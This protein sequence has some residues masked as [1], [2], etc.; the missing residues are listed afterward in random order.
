MGK[1]RPKKIKEQNQTLL[2]GQG[3]ENQDNKANGDDKKIL[4]EIEESIELGRK[5]FISK[6]T[7][8][9][10]M[11]YQPG[12]DIRQKADIAYAIKYNELLKDD[13]P[14][15]KEMLETLKKRGLWTDKDDKKIENKIEEMRELLKKKASHAG[16][17]G[18]ED[19]INRLSD[20]IKK[21][22]T[23]L[24]IITMD[25]D[26]M[27][28]NTIE[29]LSLIENYKIK[30]LHCVKEIDKDQ[31]EL[32]VWESIKELNIEKNNQFLN[33]I[34]TTCI[35]FWQGYNERFLELFA[36]RKSGK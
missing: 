1:G 7:D 3:Q 36:G 23:E 24:V 28:E 20:E 17:D 34:L 6:I 21:I 9:T 29:G 12:L 4:N 31:K 27:L 13:V 22:E 15:R 19:E 14:T 8:K 11:I 18:R 5:F 33:E 35:I 16:V 2:E 32:S 10:Y 25:R 26:S 30:L